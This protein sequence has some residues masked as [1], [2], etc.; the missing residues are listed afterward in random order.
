MDDG[1]TRLVKKVDEARVEAV[2]RPAA[3]KGS[4]ADR[5]T[6]HKGREKPQIAASEHLAIDYAVRIMRSS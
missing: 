4:A 6:R 2:F 5:K 3:K 1:L